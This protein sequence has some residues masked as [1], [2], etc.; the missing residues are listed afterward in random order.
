MAIVTNYSGGGSAT[1]SGGLVD[2]QNVPQGAVWLTAKPR[3][4][5]QPSSRGPVMVR[6]GAVTSS[7]VYPIVYPPR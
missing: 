3:K 1:I 4:L 6:A 2:F 5:G 7:H